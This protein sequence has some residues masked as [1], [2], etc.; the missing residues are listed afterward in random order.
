ML[1]TAF[2]LIAGVTAQDA[3]PA[4]ATPR[5]ILLLAGADDD[6]PDGTHEYAKSAILLAQWLDRSDVA[7]AVKTEVCFDGWPRDERVLDA[8]DA[9]VL[10]AA[11]AD[12][13]RDD[14]PFL[15]STR[16]DAIA[17]QMRRGCGLVV[18]HWGLF[19]PR[20]GTDERWLEWIGG[21]FDYESGPPSGTWAS[22]IR[23]I[24]SRVDPLTRHAVLNGVGPFELHEEWYD[25]LRFRTGDE[26]LTPLL[27]A[28][29]DDD[30]PARDR[31][32]RVVAFAVERADGGR[33]FG[34]SGG[35]FLANYEQPEFRRLLL[36]AIA[37]TAKIEVPRDG[38]TITAPE[39]KR[40]LVVTGHDYAPVQ[41][42]AGLHG[43]I[44]AP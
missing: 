8:A 16:I 43:R 20:D 13:R 35:H 44:V 6:H 19:V 32:E 21:H 7:A 15:S 18:L 1:A 5:R 26:R 17:R 40:V 34:C 28:R 14:H 42:D 41:D 9:I 3:A 29:A 39:R 33:G 37:W 10:I 4:A 38:V 36:N 31:R 2:A 25:R 24:D 11:G 12:R 27:E 22:R 23:T 30:G